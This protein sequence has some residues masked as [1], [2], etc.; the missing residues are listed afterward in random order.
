[1]VGCL[2]THPENFLSR[3][4]PNSLYHGFSEYKISIAYCV[5]QTI[6]SL[7]QKEPIFSVCKCHK[8]LGGNSA[9]FALATF[10]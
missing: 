10:F 4:V 6:L 1:M 7:C 8:L 2:F 9:I 5:L 3:E